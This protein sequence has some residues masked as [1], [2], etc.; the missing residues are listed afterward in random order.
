MKL[1]KAETFARKYFG[2]D[3][4]PDLR[5]I[6][7]WVRDGYLAGREMGPRLVYID[8]DAWLDSR[9]GS[10]LADKILRAS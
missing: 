9:T 10:D 7:S 8:E 2:P 6:R 1:I 4:R 5:T 3:D